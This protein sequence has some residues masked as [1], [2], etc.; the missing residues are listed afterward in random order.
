[1]KKLLMTLSLLTLI[2]SC[3]TT[4]TSSDLDASA[5]APGEVSNGHIMQTNEIAEILSELAPN[6]FNQNRDEWI[7]TN[8]VFDS[9][10]KDGKL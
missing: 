2:A 3:S 6:E 8:E 5:Q 1:M 10:R 9:S 4:T 7:S